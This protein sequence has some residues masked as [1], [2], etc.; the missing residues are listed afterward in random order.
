MVAVGVHLQ[1]SPAWF[2][3]GDRHR[4]KMIQVGKKEKEKNKQN[5]TNDY[6]VT[7]NCR[8]WSL[9]LYRS[10]ENSYVVLSP[11]TGQDYII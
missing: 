10:S 5:D 11:K 4:I 7:N 3:R 1:V 2:L 6:I 8:I 9:H